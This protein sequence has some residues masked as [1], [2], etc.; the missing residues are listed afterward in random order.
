MARTSKEAAF[1]LFCFVGVKVRISGHLG[2]DNGHP[3][4]VL[5][6]LSHPSSYESRLLL[7][8]GQP[9]ICLPFSTRKREKGE[10]AKQPRFKVL[11]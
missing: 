5:H 6:S 3:L 8:M 4:H 10:G 1:V 11:E 7:D 2:G 9:W